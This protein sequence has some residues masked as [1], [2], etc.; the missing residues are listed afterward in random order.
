MNRMFAE[1]ALSHET[2][3]L[4]HRK[5]AALRLFITLE[6]KPNRQSPKVRRLLRMACRNS[7]LPQGASTF[8]TL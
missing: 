3:E 7:A 8:S 4:G 2:L 1:T 6:N 5:A